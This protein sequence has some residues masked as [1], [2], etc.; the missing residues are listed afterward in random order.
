MPGL[1]GRGPKTANAFSPIMARVPDITQ[2]LNR[3]SSGDAQAFEEMVPLVYGDL[4]R[5][6]RRALQ[7]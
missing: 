3:W 1:A 6:A 5:V 2:L 4:K 7:S